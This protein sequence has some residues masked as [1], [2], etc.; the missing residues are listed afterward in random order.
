MTP[1]RRQILLLL[2]I[3]AGVAMSSCEEI[4][5][6]EGLPY[7]EKLVIHGI[8]F[9]ES[10]SSVI[11]ISRT[12]PLNIPFDT[13][14]AFLATATGSISDGE[15]TYPLEYLGYSGKYRAAGLIPQSGRSYS[16]NVSSGEFT[17]TATTTVPPVSKV[18]TAFITIESSRFGYEQYL[19]T[20]KML[21]PEA[22]SVQ[23]QTMVKGDGTPIYTSD[24]RLYSEN[25]SEDDGYLYTK[26]SLYKSEDQTITGVWV[27]HYTFAPGYYEYHQSRRGDDFEELG[28][29]AVV[30][31][32]VAG[33][34]IG[35][36]FGCAIGESTI[37]F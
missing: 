27:R 11:Q 25:S 12:L 29:P 6:A 8:L 37:N 16:L 35:I 21:L 19:V 34:A 4:L 20:C 9:A 31:W 15:K 18:D 2:L 14:Q 24:H 28:N 1:F 17:A 26:T 5:D 30:R 10:S 23:I 13:N 32:N 3:L 36:F 22:A 7:E 33:D